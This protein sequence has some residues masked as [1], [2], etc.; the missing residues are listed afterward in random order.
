M[1]LQ[2][3]AAHGGLPVFLLGHSAGGVLSCIYTLEHQDELSGL[4]CEDF[5]I[6]V[7]AP[8]FAIAAL[9]GLSHIA[10]HAHVFKLNN[11]DFSCD[12]A[13]VAAMDADPLIAHEVQPTRMVAE[14]ARADDRLRKS[15]EQITLPVLIL[16]GTAD[17]VTKPSGSR[18]FYERAGSSDKTLKLYEGH[19]HDLLNDR[20]REV[21]MAIS[22]SGS[23][24]SW[25]RPQAQPSM[26]GA[27]H[28][29]PDGRGRHAGRR[30][31]GGAALR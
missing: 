11:A 17:K 27:R 18:L 1:V 13:V 22:S 23:T 8:D 28:G 19:Y 26:W 15:F 4:I 12:P 24:P 25:R 16:H 10:P 9:K 30:A 21:V 20:D 14:L 6:E 29:P 5:A 7:P 2:A 31:G 3:K